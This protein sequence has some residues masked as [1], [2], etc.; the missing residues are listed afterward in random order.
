VKPLFLALVVVVAQA[1]CPPPEPAP[2]PEQGLIFRS[3]FGPG[4]ELGEPVAVGGGAADQWGQY[5]S[6]ADAGYE[7][8]SLPSRPGL[9][10][11]FAYLFP[12]SAPFPGYV[13]TRLVD[14]HLRMELIR[15]HA[16]TREGTRNEFGI[17]PPDS[18]T[19]ARVKL[20]L[21]LQPDLNDVLSQ[22]ENRFRQLAEWR[23]SG[24]DFRFVFN[25]RRAPTGELF[26][27]SWSQFGGGG[28]APWGWECKYRAR[29]PLGEWF[30][31][32]M[33]WRTDPVAG[34]F[35]AAA[36]GVTVADVTGRTKLNSGLYVWWPFKVYLGEDLKTYTGP[37][38]WQLVDD[39]EIW[40]DPPAEM[41]PGE[42]GCEVLE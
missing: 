18:F 33:F 27:W 26:W 11:A 5:I 12:P 1:A 16:G 21:F 31:L 7:W 40:T 24:N 20:R 8:T 36:N 35:W 30:D 19:Q 17:H 2:P 14:G 9:Q 13:S 15:Q 22:T 23:E 39:V 38:I 29:V 25:V 34:R 10:P 42:G 4:V 32:E 37:P 41:P 28:N 6:G 3:S